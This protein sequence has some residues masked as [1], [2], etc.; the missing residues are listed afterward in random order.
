MDTALLSLQGAPRAINVI[1]VAAVR[2]KQNGSTLINYMQG[3]L[4]LFTLMINQTESTQKNEI[5]RKKR[6]RERK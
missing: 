6:E 3:H 4:A 5:E 2:K 1:M